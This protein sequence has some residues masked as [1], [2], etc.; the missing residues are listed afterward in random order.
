MSTSRRRYGR[1]SKLEVI[2]RVQEA[3]A[4]RKSP[5]NWARPER[6]VMADERLREVRAASATDF[7]VVPPIYSIRGVDAAVS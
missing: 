1:E 6:S 7:R 3:A 2:R 5:A 4:R